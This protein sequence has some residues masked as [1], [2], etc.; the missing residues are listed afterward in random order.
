MKTLL[1]FLTALILFS[2]CCKTP[3][4]KTVYKDRKVIVKVP[5]KCIVPEPAIPCDLKDKTNI[6]KIAEIFRCYYDLKDTI[7]VCQ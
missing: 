4:P 6:E 5:V 2:G 7:K 3:P 1:I